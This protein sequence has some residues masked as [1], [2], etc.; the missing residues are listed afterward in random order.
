MASSYESVTD[1]RNMEFNKQKI[2]KTYKLDR[3]RA[4]IARSINL[5]A[6]IFMFIDGH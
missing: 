4:I 2:D 5:I 1:R 3:S 6:Y